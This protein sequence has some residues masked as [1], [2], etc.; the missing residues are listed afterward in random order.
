MK[1]TY[2]A[3]AIALSG[4]SCS[5]WADSV[6]GTIAAVTV[7]PDSAT[8]TRRLDVTLPAGDQ[9][10]DM[11]GLPQSVEPDTLQV[12]G[13]SRSGPRISSLEWLASPDNMIDSPQLAALKKQKD[14]LEVQQGQLQ[15]EQQAI[16][17]QQL[18]LQTMAKEG[19]GK[20]A[21]GNPAQQVQSGVQV[22]GSE[23]KQAGEA[24]ASVTHRLALL[25]SQLQTVNDALTQLRDK[26]ASLR[27]VRIH[28]RSDGQPFQMN[29]Q[30]RVLHARW[31]PIYDAD[32][33]TKSRQVALTQAALIQ[34]NTGEDWHNVALTLST[35][36]PLQQAAAPDLPS[37]WVDVQDEE[38]GSQPA[39]AR[40]AML[41]AKAAAPVALMSA[42]QT[43][44]LAAIQSSAYHVRFVLASQTTLLAD[45]QSH[46]VVLAT[47]TSPVTLSL[48]A[49][50]RLDPHAYLYGNVRNTTDQPWLAGH[51]QLSRD[52]EPVGQLDQPTLASQATVAL[53][54]GIDP[55]ITL[56]WQS[57]Q[58]EAGQGGLLSKT[59]VQKRKYRLQA[60][61]ARTDGAELLVLDSWPVAKQS[62]IEVTPLDGTTPPAPVTTTQQPGVQR[63]TLALPSKQTVT[64]DTGYQITYPQGKTLRH[65]ESYGEIER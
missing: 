55:A 22:L 13:F 60:S 41:E 32:L 5:V 9:F 54:F 64:L 48:Q 39:V 26:D 56:T 35:A 59:S 53:G 15:A 42:R 40:S 62:S 6:Q 25:A 3:L 18:F 50:P 20:S 1:Q 23:M 19:L 51:W 12:T 58:D 14:D 7:Y 38:R 47:Q 24:M 63:W 52:G 36:Q 34:Q 11:V 43:D 2:L 57:I 30:Y 8:V 10:I 46:R 65:Y 45:G 44:E 29:V 28:L 37:Q 27:T 4:L 33:L 31:Q 49:I 17:T 16:S 61:N 21:Q